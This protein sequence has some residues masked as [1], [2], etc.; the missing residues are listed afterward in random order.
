M[1]LH[2]L[3]ETKVCNS[4]LYPESDEDIW[5]HE[6]LTMSV[7]PLGVHIT[8]GDSKG[9]TF[10]VQ[11]KIVYTHHWAVIVSLWVLRGTVNPAVIGTFLVHL[12]SVNIKY[13]L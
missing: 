12:N 11:K 9:R 2:E 13:G 4:M 10:N 6:D 8:K 1:L 3:Y 5:K 7:S